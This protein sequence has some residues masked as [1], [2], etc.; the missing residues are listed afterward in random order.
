MS[1]HIII[2]GYNLIRRSPTLSSIEQWSLEEGRDALIDRLSSYKRVRH[3]PITVVFDGTH[4]DSCLERKT[5]WKGIDV[6]FSRR[7]ELADTVIKRIVARERERAVVVTSDRDIANFA[8]GHGATIMDSIE[9]EK[10]IEMA[11][12][13]ERMTGDTGGEDEV[14]WV[15]TTKKK[16]PARRPPRQK[17]KK[18]ARESKL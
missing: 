4:A 2:D 12:Q 6:V 11:T 1:L 13:M 7:G 15:P 9:F 18:R 3:H 17:R 8:E 10:K 14:G 5:A 16:G